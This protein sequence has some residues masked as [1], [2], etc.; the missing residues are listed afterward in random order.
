MRKL[1]LALAVLLAAPAALAK[2]NAE[3]VRHAS[4]VVVSGSADHMDQV[5][6]RAGVSYVVV[7]PRVMLQSAPA[8]SAAPVDAANVTTQWLGSGAKVRVL[9]KKDSYTRVRDEQ[10]NEGWVETDAL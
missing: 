2:P 8:P 6:K 7:N 3:E 5:L 1:L 4:V 9:E 10:G